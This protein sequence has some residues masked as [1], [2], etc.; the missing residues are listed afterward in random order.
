MTVNFNQRTAELAMVLHARPS[1]LFLI[2]VNE[3]EQC[4][5]KLVTLHAYTVITDN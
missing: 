3:S 1:V 5:A 2:T 4:F